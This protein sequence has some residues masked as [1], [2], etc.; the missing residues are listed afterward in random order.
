MVLS[1]PKAFEILGLQ[2][3]ADLNLVTQKY[4]QLA[5]K[6]YPQN[7]N[8]SQESLKKFKQISLA[9]KRLTSKDFKQDL[10]LTDCMSIF[11][12]VAYGRNVT[13]SSKYASSDSSDE[14][15]SDED[16]SSDSD[17]ESPLNNNTKNKDLNSQA[18]KSS[19]PNSEITEEERE[20]KRAEKRRAKKKR[21]RERKRLEKEQN[22][23]PSNKKDNKTTDKN[24]K[25]KEDGDS[26]DDT[27]FDQQSAFF[28]KVVSKKKKGGPSTENSHVQ[29]NNSDEELEVDPRVLRS[30]QLAVRGNEMAQVEEYTAAIQLFSE[31][32]SLDPTDFRFFGNRSYCFDRTEQYDKALRDAEKAIKL[33]KD[34]PKGY[35]RKGRSLAGLKNFAEAEKAFMQVLKLDKN[36]DDAVSEL[37]HVKVHQ[38]RDMGFSKPRS[39]AAIKKHNS[40][41]AALDSLLTGCGESLLNDLF[42]SDDENEGFSVHRPA[43]IPPPTSTSDVKM[44]PTN[45]EGLTALWVGN[46]LPSVTEKRLNQLFSKFGPVTSVRPLPEKFCAFINFKTK[47]AAGRAMH[48]LQNTEVDG[49]KLKIKFPDNPLSATSGT[50]GNITIRKP[51]APGVVKVGR[52]QRRPVAY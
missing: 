12:Q 19:L 28:T 18:N 43:P 40:V 27:S 29:N 22:T 38:L 45:P 37:F 49:Q 13:N 32:I 7:E 14:N 26:G 36:C 10:S 9:Y 33:D 31:A 51:T 8:H 20:Q 50:P 4:K 34:W 44:D 6:Y 30:R 17:D 39:E 15:N 47:E 23:K 25:Q 1:N 42:I 46:V 24:G 2:T 5:M 41:Q 11:K 48:Q 21:Q 52:S 35:F 3:G 16:Y